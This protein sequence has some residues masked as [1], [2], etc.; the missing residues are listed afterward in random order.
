MGYGDVPSKWQIL[1]WKVVNVLAL[2]PAAFAYL[3]TSVTSENRSKRDGRTW[4]K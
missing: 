2:V 3:W 4:R 1:K